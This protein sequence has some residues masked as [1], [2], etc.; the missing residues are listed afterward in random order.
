MSLRD[1]L[2]VAVER[3]RGEAATAWATFDAARTKARDEG[4]ITAEE[5]VKEESPAFEKLHGL[6]RAYGEKADE[7]RR[8]Q[9]RYMLLLEMED[10]PAGDPER[11][12]TDTVTARDGGSAFM[13]RGQKFVDS[14]QYK[15]LVASNTIGVKGARIHMNPVKVADRAEVK[16]L[17][18]G[19][20][21]TSAGAFILNDRQPGLLELLQRP[22]VVR[23]L[24]SV[25]ETDS[26]TV[27]WVRE[28]SFTNSAA[29]TAEA[30]ATTGASGTKP[31]SA[32]AFDV[33]TSPVRTIPHW[34]PATRRALADASQVRSLID[35]RLQDGINLRLDS[36]M[37]NGDGT[38]ENLR[39]ILNTAG[40]ISQAKGVDSSVDAVLKAMTQIRLGFME[41]DA[42]LMHPNDWQEVR[43]SKDA[44]G[45][46][47]YGPPSQA[48][49]STM[50]GVAV[51][52][53]TVIPE[54]TGLVGSFREAELWMREGITVFATDSHSD[55]FIR[56]MV[57]LLAEMRAAFT[58][59][60]PA[61]FAQVTGI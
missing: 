39:G 25:M 23:G 29:E 9:E 47:L 58:V 38:G 61:A 52:G 10:G 27:E 21:D 19:L 41:P 30:T 12:S 34:I 57:V 4:S 46:Y 20:S 35:Q 40:I 8:L 28:T 48:G 7:S 43:L 45:N 44:N 22:M 31:E 11:K 26:D 16:A 51:T 17:I 6:H 32:I 18:T 14:D 53:N 49:A 33:V 59:R 55:F 24:V 3:S 37:I 1:D 50:W 13:S 54:G 15:A 5:L 2:R 36:Q 56:N 60:R 42:V